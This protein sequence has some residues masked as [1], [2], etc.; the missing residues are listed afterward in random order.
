LVITEH[1]IQFCIYEGLF[2]LTCTRKLHIVL[3]ASLSDLIPCVWNQN[4]KQKTL[5]STVNKYEKAASAAA[6]WEKSSLL[7]LTYNWLQSS[8]DAARN[9]S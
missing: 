8:H 4:C 1:W 3:I 9:S 6:E 2:P 5:A 7:Y